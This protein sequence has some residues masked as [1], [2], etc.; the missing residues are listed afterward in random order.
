MRDY[1]KVSPQF[2]IGRTGKSLRSAGAEAQLVSLYLLTNPHANM[3]GLYYMPLMFI[4]HETGLGM[5]GACKCHQSRFLSLRR[6][7]R[8]GLGAGNGRSSNR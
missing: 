6:A 3:I 1:G 4:A 8:D 2:W 7:I 5:E